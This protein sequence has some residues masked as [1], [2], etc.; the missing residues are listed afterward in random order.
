MTVKITKCSI[1]TIKVAHAVLVSPKGD[2]GLRKS[3]MTCEHIYKEVKQMTLNFAAAR[4][5]VQAA[6]T[7]A[8]VFPEPREIKTRYRRLMKVIHPDRVSADNQLQAT[9]LVTALTRFYESAQTALGSGTY[10]VDTSVVVMTSRH[11]THRLEREQS[12]YCDITAGFRS[13]S[14]VGDD[15]Y[16]TFVKI[17]RT[18]SDNDLLISETSALR[19]LRDTAG[20]EFRSFYPELIDSFVAANDRRR[21]QVNV[22]QLMDGFY[23]LDEIRA[24]RPHGL[25]PLHAAWIWRRL[26]WALGGAHKVGLIHGAVLPQHVVVH[27]KMHG[28]LLVDWCYSQQAVDQTFAP[29]KAIVGNRQAWYPTSVSEKKEPSHRLDTVMAARTMC[30]LLGGDGVSMAMPDTVPSAMKR[31]LVRITSGVNDSSALE[32]LAQFDELLQQLGSPYYPRRYRE[33]TL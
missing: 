21:L 26:L 17:A 10:G 25:S 14:H 15:D 24:F 11:G 20:D 9:E 12:D 1:N 23:N 29:I 5:I 3:P 18:P 8:D 6:Q 4:V 27:P 16:D 19:L 32:L 33:L 22:V 31:Y 13:Q 28:V 30:F 7:Y 2:E